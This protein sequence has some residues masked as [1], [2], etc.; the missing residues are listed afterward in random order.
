MTPTSSRAGERRRAAPDPAAPPDPAPASSRRPGAGQGYLRYLTRRLVYGVL[1]LFLAFTGSFFLLFVVPGDAA[2]ALTFGA[3]GEGL[4]ET[5]DA[6]RE[7]LGIDRPVLV[8]YG[9]A[10]VNA[11]RGDFGISFA[12]KAPATDVYFSAFGQ[13]FQLALTGLLLAVAFGVTLG[14]LTELSRF[15]WLREALVTIPPLAASLPAFLTALLLLQFFAFGIGVI[16]PF[17]DESF[18]GLLVAAV[19]IALPGGANIAQLLT[20]NLQRTMR[21]PYV[22][23]L[24][25]WGLSRREIVVKHG[26][27]NAILPVLTSFGTTVGNIFAGTVLTETVFS[28]NGVGRIT[29]DAVS[30]HDTPVVLVAVTV[31]ALIFV[32][33]NLV[34]DALYPVIDK[35]IQRT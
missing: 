18:V 16:E 31:S 20:V 34:V 12:H 1:V 13:T 7:L 23:T 3:S 22:E 32:V 33:V 28:R 15:A 19:C 2:G 27:K 30:G 21:S 5:L 35:R 29:V 9:E 11:V 4:E 24:Q 26:F 17:G 6:Q 14:L 8:Q 25:N 10:L